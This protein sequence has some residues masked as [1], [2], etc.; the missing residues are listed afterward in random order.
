ML[1]SL[2]DPHSELVLLRSCLALPKI[3]FSLR[4]VETSS[5]L[6]VLQ[7]YDRVTREGISRII[8]VPL[9]EQQWLQ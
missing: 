9:S 7:E 6:E 1:P 3:I 8:G 2:E 5:H 4:T